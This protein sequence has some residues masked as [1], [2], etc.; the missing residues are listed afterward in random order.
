LNIMGN[1]SG[2]RWLST[3][4]LGQMSGHCLF[5]HIS[6]EPMAPGFVLQPRGG[7]RADTLPPGSVSRIKRGLSKLFENNECGI[8][9]FRH[10]IWLN[11][12]VMNFC[13]IVLKK[14]TSCKRP[15][16]SGVREVQGVSL[17]MKRGLGGTC[18]G[19]LYSPAGT[20]WQKPLWVGAGGPRERPQSANVELQ[21]GGINNGEEILESYTSTSKKCIN[22][23]ICHS[24][25]K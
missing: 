3:K 1:S 6:H 13:V 11:V 25:T 21:N 12:L 9:N 19:R 4:P 2:P 7:G 22:E 24:K 15:R 20:R 8:F 10:F 18:R 5:L 14:D 17:A 16:G 23:T